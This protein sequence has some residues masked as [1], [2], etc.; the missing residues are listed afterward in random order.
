MIPHGCHIYAKA[1]DMENATMCTYTKSDHALPHWKCVLRCCAKCPCIN[2]LDQETDNK[3]SETTASIRF[4]VYH[5]ISRR[6]AH[7]RIA[8]K[9]K[10]ICYMCEQKSFFFFFLLR[11]QK[12]KKGV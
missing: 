7:G 12:S 8:L 11:R 6:T 2:L 5:I 9:E 10:K 1:S 3:Y 4:H